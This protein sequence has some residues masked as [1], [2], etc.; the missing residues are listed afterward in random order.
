MK[1]I[2]LLF[3]IATMV[4]SCAV[5][6]DFTND[7]SAENLSY[8][9]SENSNLGTYKG[10]FTTLDSKFRGVVAVHLPHES[11]QKL[12]YPYASVKMTDGETYLA[13]AQQL[14]DDK[15]FV[16]QLWFES[17]D[18]AF[19]FTVNANGSDPIISNVTF[20]GKPSDIVVLKETALAPVTP[21]TGTYEC[22]TCNGHPVL[23]TGLE[24]SFNFVFSTP[25]GNGTI[26]TQS[27]L[28]T[29]T[30]NG[31]GVQ[32]NCVADG[33]FTTCAIESGDGSTTTTGF[34]ANG[35][36]VIWNATHKFNNEVT[37]PDDCSSIVGTWQW[38][39]N[40]YGLITGTFASDAG[41]PETLYSEDFQAFAG[42]GFAPNPVTG[43]LDSDIIIA[44]GFNSGSLAFGGTQTTG[45]FARGIDVDGNVNTGGIYAFDLPG[46]RVFGIQPGG[47]D[48][49][50][51]D[52]TIRVPNS[53]G[54]T[55]SMIEFRVDV[56]AN[57]DQ[58]RS[59]RY[60]FQYS[61]DGINYINF[62][63]Y[64]TV[65]GSDTNGFQFVGTQNGTPAVSVPPG[66][67]IYMRIAGDDLAG[68][69]LRDEIGFDNI[70][71]IVQ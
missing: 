18:I 2:F 40:S 31:I 42:S 21:V 71:I 19:S 30:Y 61:I 17:E 26:T 66:D 68:S 34:L 48:F 28:G 14:V 33:T 45:D 57:N 55:L 36:P 10:V 51:G 52:V 69:G 7:D 60:T 4:L 23:G 6:N 29:T 38:Q 22:G 47:A 59:S 54:R 65:A 49:T 56:Y 50:P 1:K 43:Q 15:A 9:L 44:S 11:N 58:N 25:D 16:D 63:T 20:K 3:A 24:Q 64:D 5:E 53:T 41:C 27:A 67:F 37:G 12:K 32:N 46:T 70:E 13:K 39:S 62:A 8:D 35:N